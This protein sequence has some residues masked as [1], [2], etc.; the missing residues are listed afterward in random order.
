MEQSSIKQSK[1]KPNRTRSSPRDR[2]ECLQMSDFFFFFLFFFHVKTISDQPGMTVE[3]SR[4]IPLWLFYLRLK[5]KKKKSPHDVSSVI[6]S[7]SGCVSTLPCPSRTLGAVA[8]TNGIPGLP[9]EQPSG[10]ENIAGSTEFREGRGLHLP[11]LHSEWF[12]IV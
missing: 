9:L 8:L 2:G 5:L 1:T 12:V 6:G 7:F 11:L 10:E 3:E 4:W